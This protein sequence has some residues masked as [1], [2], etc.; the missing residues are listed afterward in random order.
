MTKMNQNRKQRRRRRWILIAIAGGLL[1]TAILALTAA[2]RPHIQIDP[3][4]LATVTRGDIAQAVVATGKIEP[5]T[6]VEVKS[7]A[8]GIVKKIDVD[9]GDRVRQGQVLV[10]LDREELRAEVEEARAN[11]AAAQA[12]EASAV[13]TYQRNQVDAEGP[14]VPF[15]KAA[16]R[17]DR[18]LAA[19]GILA[20]STLDD[21]EKSYQLALNRKMSALRSVAVSRADVAKAKAQ[22]EQAQAGLD[23]A[24]ENLRNATIVS[25]I[26]GIVLSRNVEVGDAVS[27]ILVMGSQATLVMMLGDVSSV[28]VKGKVDQADIG[29]V[30]V[31]QL[32]RIVVES[33]KDKTFKGKVTRIS[34]MGVEKDNVTTFEV[35]ISIQN[36]NGELK[37]NMSA[38]AQILLNQKDHVLILPES[39]V[40][41]GKDQKTFVEVPD[42]R[43]EQG[44]K[45]IPVRLGISNGIQTEVLSGLHEGQQVILQ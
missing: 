31:G 3:S 29:K 18:Q 7:K 11:L 27:S 37:A 6:K 19:A 15:L 25:P 38:N 14:D 4:K 2:L 45:K 32:A 28:Y 13:A 12:A 23:Q 1:S 9:Y 20:E 36:P 35:R 8:S 33:F 16:V 39:A 21:A 30:Y 43:T 24:E 17:R 40:I 22:V 10:E 34:P 26:N 41:Y 42:P 5:L 44:W